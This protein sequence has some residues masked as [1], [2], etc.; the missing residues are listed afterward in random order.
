V[1][2]VR[3]VIGTGLFEL[4]VLVDKA[5]GAHYAVDLNPR[6]FGQMSLD[7]AHGH[8]LPVLWY[9]DVAGASAPTRPA[10]RRPPQIWHDAAASYMD[11]AVR[12]GRG[13]HRLAVAREVWGRFR[14]PSVGAMHDWLDPLPGVVFAW[15]HVRHPRAFVRTFVTDSELYDRGFQQHVLEDPG[16]GGTE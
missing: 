7:M 2:A 4:E 3:E 9:N 1:R 12:V 10:Q 14:S 5:S 15:K 6:G 13:P 11:L 8:D 16:D